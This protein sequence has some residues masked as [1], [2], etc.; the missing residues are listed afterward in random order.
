M[1]RGKGLGE[2]WWWYVLL[3]VEV[4]VESFDTDGFS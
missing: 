2:W 4:K 1:G 3:M